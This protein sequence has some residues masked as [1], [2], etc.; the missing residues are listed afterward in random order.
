MILMFL[1][2]FNDCWVFYIKKK[3]LIDSLGIINISIFSL[4]ILILLIVMFLC[5]FFWYL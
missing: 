5:I 1:K 4:R 2:K 3:I